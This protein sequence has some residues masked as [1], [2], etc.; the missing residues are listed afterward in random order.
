MCALVFLPIALVADICLTTVW[1]LSRTAYRRFA[2]THP[3]TDVLGQ[4]VIAL[5]V[6]CISWM[7]QTSLDKVVHLS[8]LEYLVT[9]KTLAGFD[10]VI[11]ADC[12]NVFVGCISVN[13][14]KVVIVQGL[15]QLAAV[16]SLCFFATVTTSWHWIQLQ[17]SSKTYASVTSRSSRPRPVS[18]TTSF[19]IP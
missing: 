10:P 16:S 19:P 13:D 17:L 9:M 11:V 7:L 4:Q 18:M 6:R 8:T 5:D 3:Q 14:H 1:P 12:F 2:G 15:E